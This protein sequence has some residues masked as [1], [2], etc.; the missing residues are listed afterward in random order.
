MSKIVDEIWDAV[1]YHVEHGG[2]VG[3]LLGMPVWQSPHIKEDKVVLISMRRGMPQRLMAVIE[4]GPEAFST[5][6]LLNE[7]WHRAKR[8]ARVKLG[9]ERI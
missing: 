7:I 2:N 9:L 3:M 4:T 5:S 8:A 1:T 6:E